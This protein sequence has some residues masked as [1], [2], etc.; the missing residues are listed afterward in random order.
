MRGLSV[1]VVLSVLLLAGCGGSSGSDAQTQ[2]TAPAYNGY[3]AITIPVTTGSTARCRHEADAFSREA[4]KFLAPFPSDSDTHLVVARVQFYEFTAHR[5]DLGILRDAF[6]RHAT[7]KQR[8]TIVDR[9]E[10]MFL[11]DTGR[12]LTGA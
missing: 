4:V 12:E 9:I 1:A 8:R 11:G 7:P 6:S 2:V 10:F 3:P 5:C